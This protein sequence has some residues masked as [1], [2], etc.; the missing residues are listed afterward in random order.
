MPNARLASEQ[1]RKRGK[2][3]S[4]GIGIA[5]TGCG[6]APRGKPRH[7]RQIAAD[8]SPCAAGYV[9]VLLT[10]A[11]TYHSHVVSPS[12]NCQTLSVM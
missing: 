9:T 10:S 1:E 3:G 7:P 8:L 2:L 12:H 4:H 5:A 11:Q 6:N